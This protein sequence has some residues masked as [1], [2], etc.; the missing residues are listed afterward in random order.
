MPE[1]Y[2]VAVP[3]G[4]PRRCPVLIQSI[5]ACYKTLTEDLTGELRGTHSSVKSIE[6]KLDRLSLQ[7]WNQQCHS[8]R[9]FDHCK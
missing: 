4:A 5:I 9:S 2:A 7:K 6:D 8:K 3:D 1:R